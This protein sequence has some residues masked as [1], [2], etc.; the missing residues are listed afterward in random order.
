MNLGS[1]HIATLWRLSKAGV[2]CKGIVMDGAKGPRLIVVEAG[3]IVRWEKFPAASLLRNRA[4]EI[5][6]DLKKSGW[7]N[8]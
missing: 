8:D 3:R 5:L 7:G 1:L 6:K 4:G 2:T